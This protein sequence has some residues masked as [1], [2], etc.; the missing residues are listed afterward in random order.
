MSIYSIPI[1]AMASSIN[2]FLQHYGSSSKLNST[3]QSSLQG[4]QMELGAIG[5]PL[6]YNID[7]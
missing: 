4:L 5:N 2:L 3:L 6:E 7:I 1:E